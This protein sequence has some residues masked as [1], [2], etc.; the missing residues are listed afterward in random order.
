MS[1]KYIGINSKELVKEYKEL[2]VK[3]IYKNVGN[4]CITKE[5]AEL[6]LE[7]LK[8]D[9][10]IRS[11]GKSITYGTISYKLVL[12]IRMLYKILGVQVTI[13]KVNNHGGLG[14]N[15]IYRIGTN[16][17]FFYLLFTCTQLI[18]FCLF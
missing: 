11:N 9:A 7:G 5:N 16:I 13:K 12:Q 17:I 15:P 8:A 10:S 3:A 4:V 6:L 2:G 14:K 18:F 1:K